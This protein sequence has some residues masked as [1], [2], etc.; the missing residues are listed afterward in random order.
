M[1]LKVA[2]VAL[3]ISFVIF[4]VFS[5]ATS[6][7]LNQWKDTKIP[8]AD[9]I[10]WGYT[11]FSVVQRTDE[12]SRQDVITSYYLS[13]GTN[14]LK[15]EEAHKPGVRPGWV[16]WCSQLVRPYRVDANPN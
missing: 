3:A 12:S 5:P 8:M 6:P 11:I 16:T 4:A 2:A 1:M 14:V 7:D 15:C 13:N 10:A 9:F